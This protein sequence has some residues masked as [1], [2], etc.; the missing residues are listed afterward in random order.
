MGWYRNLDRVGGWTA[1]YIQTEQSWEFPEVG[2]SIGELEGG[3]LE[4]Q[5]KVMLSAPRAICLWGP[6]CQA[7]PSRQPF[8]LKTRCSHNQQSGALLQISLAALEGRT[9]IFYQNWKAQT[10]CRDPRLLVAKV[11][12]AL[13]GLIKILQ[14][15]PQIDLKREGFRNA[16]LNILT[17]FSSFNSFNSCSSFDY[18]IVLIVSVVSKCSQVSLGSL[19]H[20]YP[21][22]SFLALYFDIYLIPLNDKR[23]CHVARI[24][25]I[26]T[27]PRPSTLV[28][29][30]HSKFHQNIQGLI[31][32]GRLA[33]WD[34]SRHPCSCLITP[35]THTRMNATTTTT[36]TNK[37][38]ISHDWLVPAGW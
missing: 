35:Y 31:L 15:S 12:T 30:Q 37:Q 11:Q 17:S 27:A 33:V 16:C 23:T 5:R 36:T 21:Q 25:L 9:A 14:P 10:Q 1:W 20:W 3:L 26:I 29:M 13:Q 32:T 38:I 18:S 4:S 19:F 28:T 2:I 8:L 7:C 6:G 22:T 34:M 24:K